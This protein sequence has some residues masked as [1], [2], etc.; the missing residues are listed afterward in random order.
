MSWRYEGKRW[1]RAGE[2]VLCPLNKQVRRT[3]AFKKVDIND[4]PGPWFWL[5]P[6][7]CMLLLDW[8]MVSLTHYCITQNLGNQLLHIS[9]YL[10]QPCSSVL[11]GSNTNRDGTYDKETWPCYVRQS[12]HER[13]KQTQSRGSRATLTT[14]PRSRGPQKSSSCTVPKNKK[15]LIVFS[16]CNSAILLWPLPCFVLALITVEE[17]IVMEPL[18]STQ[19]ELALLTII[20]IINNK[21]MWSARLELSVRLFKSV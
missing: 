12:G 4:A 14:P 20:I 9:A 7:E 6:P 3:A 17:H 15:D 2:H 19:S 13:K 16:K 1:H 10:T 5:L 8:K 18:S 21:Q 11:T